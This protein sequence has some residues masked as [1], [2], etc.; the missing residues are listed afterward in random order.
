MLLLKSLPVTQTISVECFVDVNHRVETM[1]QEACVTWLHL[2]ESSGKTPKKV[3]QDNRYWGRDSKGAPPANMSFF[4]TGFN[5]LS[6]DARGTYSVEYGKGKSV[7]NQWMY[8]HCVIA[9]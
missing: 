5:S 4:T 2:S 9:I 6:T 1:W 7:L 8:S 3:S